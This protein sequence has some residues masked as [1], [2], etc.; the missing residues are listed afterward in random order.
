M[1]LSFPSGGNFDTR[2]EGQVMIT[3]VT[4]PWNKDMVFHWAQYVTP[5]AKMLATSGA[6]VGIAVFHGSMLCTPDALQALRECAIASVKLGCLAHLVV[7]ANGLEGRSQVEPMFADVYQGVCSYQ[8]FPDL[9]AAL[10]GATKLL[11]EHQ[12]EAHKT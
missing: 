6:Y 9:A 11:G 4:G 5:Y 3:E 12:G 7:A 2:V 10:A 1:T 8:F